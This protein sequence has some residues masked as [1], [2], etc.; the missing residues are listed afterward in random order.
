MCLVLRRRTEEDQETSDFSTQS[1]TMN[2]NQILNN[3]ELPKLPHPATDQTI[4]RTVT[5]TQYHQ[6]SLNPH[7]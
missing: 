3:Q 4:S 6:S 2:H 1:V 5:V 7:S